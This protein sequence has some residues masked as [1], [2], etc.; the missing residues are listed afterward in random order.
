MLDSVSLLNFDWDADVSDDVRDRLFQRIATVVHKWRLEMPFM[1]W[2]ETTAP[3]ANL[4][5]QG[6]IVMSPFLAP[7]L[8]GG[9]REM[10]VLVKLLSDTKNVK[11]LLDRIEAEAANAA[12]K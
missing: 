10:Q 8:P 4:A 12:R 6:A 2:L 3:L 11:L 5:G 9:L 7:V 1:L